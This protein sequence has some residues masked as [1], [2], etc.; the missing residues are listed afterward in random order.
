MLSPDEYDQ[1]GACS[2]H[3]ADSVVHGDLHVIDTS[4]G[5]AP[6]LVI[7]GASIVIDNEGRWRGGYDDLRQLA[8]C[9]LDLRVAGC[10]IEAIPAASILSVGWLLRLWGHLSTP[11]G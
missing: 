2:G 1:R 11:L 3:T 4:R 10:S 9:G 6:D 7:V 5:D 8:R